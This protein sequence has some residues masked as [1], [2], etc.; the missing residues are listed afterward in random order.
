MVKPVK[1]ISEL[2]QKA[3][4]SE[5]MNQGKLNEFS[6]ALQ[7][8]MS[9]TSSKSEQ[10]YYYFVA[11]ITGWALV[12]TSTI[13]K[14][15]LLGVEL[16]NITFILNV[17]IL[18]STYSY[19]KFITLSFFSSLLD[20]SLRIIY[21]TLYKSFSDNNVTEL[22]TPTTFEEMETAIDSIQKPN[23]NISIITTW[24]N[25]FYFILLTTIPVIVIVWCSV[26]LTLIPEVNLFLSIATITIVF[27]FLLRCA[28][29]F[30][31]YFNLI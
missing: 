6:V 16:T 8:K 7:D 15:T 9:R 22:L 21:K 3:L 14:I 12:Y 25:L 31:Q 27:I 30:F 28:F 10:S 19:Y 5:L 29:S 20:A 26:L 23:S 11:F 1:T 18:L 13:Q 17:L 2:T 24:W 4:E